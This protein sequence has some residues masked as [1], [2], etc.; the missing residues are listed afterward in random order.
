ML[1]RAFACLV[2]AWL[3]GCG[4]AK[5]EEPAAQDATPI[6]GCYASPD[7]P[8]IK[9]DAAAISIIGTDK[10]FP[11]RYELPKIGTVLRIPMDAVIVGEQFLFKSSDD[12]FYRVL[13]S[14][15]GPIVRIAFAPR[16]VVKDYRQA[17]GGCRS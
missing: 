14:D 5:S 13:H 15:A 7:A 2:I 9:I 17:T 6:F 4:P 8:S 10:T 12:R 1:N 11:Y 16:G 3:S